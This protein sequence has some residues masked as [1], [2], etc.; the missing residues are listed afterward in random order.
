MYA[1]GSRIILTHLLKHKELFV[2][3]SGDSLL[4]KNK[5]YI[6]NLFRHGSH[7]EK[8]GWRSNQQRKEGDMEK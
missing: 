8:K 5:L 2:Q 3:D 1:K 4:I 7:K 6:W